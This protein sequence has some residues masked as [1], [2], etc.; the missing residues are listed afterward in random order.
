MYLKKAVVNYIESSNWIKVKGFEMNYYTCI[1]TITTKIAI[2]YCNKATDC[3][4]EY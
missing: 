2:T 1:I 4:I 3:R